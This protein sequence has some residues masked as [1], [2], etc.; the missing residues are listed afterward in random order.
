MIER[1][2]WGPRHGQGHRTGGAKLFVFVHHSGVVRVGP[3]STIAEE[4]AELRTIEN[5]HARKTNP[6]RIA[7][8]ALGA[9]TGRTYEGTGWA[10]IGA[11]TKN[12]NSSGYGYCFMCDGRVQV[13]PQVAIDS[14]HEW[15]DE[16]VSLGHLHPNFVIRGHRD[17]VNTTCPGDLIYDAVVA[18]GRLKAPPVVEREAAARVRPTLRHGSGGKNAPPDL[19]E[20]VRQLQRMLGMPDR[21]RTG[22]FWDIT[23]TEVRAFQKRGGLKVDGLVGKFTWDALELVDRHTG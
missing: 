16:G 22:L 10:F 9:L 19:R 4:T 11:H 1:A 23:D 7:Y 3:K 21:Y 17:E 6:P 18:P 8:T 5:G 12:R 13:L 2:V 20:A 15:C 14:F